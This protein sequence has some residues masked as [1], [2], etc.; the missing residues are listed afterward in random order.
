MPFGALVFALALAGQQIPEGVRYHSATTEVNRAA[1]TLLEKLFATPTEKA[2]FSTVSDVVVVCGPGLWRVI[3]SSIIESGVPTKNVL[4]VIPTATGNQQL[5]GR[6]FQTAKA[7][8]ILWIAVR[9]IADD[10]RA[11]KPVTKPPPFTLR[12]A[13][14]G[15]IS[16]FWSMIPFDIEEPLFVVDQGKHRF[17]A[18]L[19]NKSAPKINWI[20]LLP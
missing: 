8:E 9:A 4:L 12:K 11:E 10:R 2:D 15:E 17:L 6:A 7:K 5:E 16:Y 13:R 14:P 18:N 20:D 3:K 1:Q 19:S